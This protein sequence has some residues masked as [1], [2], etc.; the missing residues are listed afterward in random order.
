MTEVSHVAYHSNRL[1][2]RNTIVPLFEER[3]V[4]IHKCEA[5][6]YFRLVT[7]SVEQSDSKDWRRAMACLNM[8]LNMISI[9]NRMLILYMKLKR[10][11]KTKT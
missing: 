9:I 7:P 8:I 6:N 2:K 1:F 3:I 5:T 4:L 11:S 10:K